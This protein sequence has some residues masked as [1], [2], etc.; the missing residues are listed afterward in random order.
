MR[1]IAAAVIVSIIFAVTPA[2][3]GPHSANP[4]SIS[5]AMCRMFPVLC[6]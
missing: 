5:A 1:T 6:R 2:V 4:D 3:P